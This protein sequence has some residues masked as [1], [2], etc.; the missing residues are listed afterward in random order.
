MAKYRITIENLKGGDY[1]NA[2]EIECD[3]FVILADKGESVEA[4]VHNVSRVDVATM[5]AEVPKV[6]AAAVLAQGIVESEKAFR[7]ATLQNK[8]SRFMEGKD[9]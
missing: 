6:Y 4:A 2:N 8:M 1:E 3:G 7:E 9:E 5:I